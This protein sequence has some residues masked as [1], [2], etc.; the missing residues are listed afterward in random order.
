M[1]THKPKKVARLSLNVA[2][3]AERSSRSRVFRRSPSIRPLT[4]SRR[5]STT[6]S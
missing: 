1:D 2:V 3:E 6:L 4:I 5:R